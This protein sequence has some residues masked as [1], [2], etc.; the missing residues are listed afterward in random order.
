V[1]RSAPDARSALSGAL[2][3]I[4]RS[5]SKSASMRRMAS[6]ASGEITA[7][8]LPCALRRAFSARSAMAK[9]GRRA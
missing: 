7:D 5:I 4:V 9:N 1:A 6:S 3:L 2:A 8:V